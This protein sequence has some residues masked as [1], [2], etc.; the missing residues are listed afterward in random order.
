MPDNHGKKVHIIAEAGTNH[1]GNLETAKKLA[2]VAAAAQADSV[3]FQI[4]YPEGLYLPKFYQSGNYLDNEVYALRLQGMLTDDCYRALAVFCREQGLPFSASVFDQRGIDLVDELKAPYIKIASCDLNNSALL[5]KA[6]ETG[7]TL[8]ISTGMATLGEIERAV[9]DIFATGNRDLV[10]MHCVSIYPCPLER[11][12]LGFIDVLK[13]AFGLPVGLSDHTE[14]SLAAAIAVSKGVEWIEKHI[15]LD[16]TSKGFDHAYAMEPESFSRY[17]VD[18]KDS[19]KACSKPE[20]KVMGVEAEV[21]TRARR[22]V[23]ANRD[24][25]EGEQVFADDIVIV[26]PEG[27]MVPNEAPLLFGKRAS[28]LIRQY[29]PLSP[30]LFS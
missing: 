6:A 7:R 25:Q 11:M 15:T 29:E 28:R 13:V 1:N 14:N 21:K 26:R 12:N 16:R 4:I 24:I 10:L 19:L 22:S 30:D 8:I 20:K 5:I 17:V 2:E 18:I 9:A 27:L 23:Y 3:K